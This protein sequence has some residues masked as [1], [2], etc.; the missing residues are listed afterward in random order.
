MFGGVRPSGIAA[1]EWL[2]WVPS[3]QLLRCPEETA[4]GRSEARQGKGKLGTFLM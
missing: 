3:R 1:L 4:Q 2:P